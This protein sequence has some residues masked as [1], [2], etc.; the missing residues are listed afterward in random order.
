MSAGVRAWRVHPAPLRAGTVAVPGDKS[1]THRAI[2]LGLLAA[3]ETEV[4]GGNAGED[5]AASLA[6][7]AALGA[8]IDRSGDAWRITGVARRPA[9][10]LAPIDCG[11]SGT[12]LRLLA[13]V[14]AGAPI[15][16]ELTGDESLRRRPVDRV[17]RPLRAMGARA[18]AAGEDRFP[19]LVVE[20][21]SLRGVDFEQPTAS[22]QVASC[23]LL[24]ALSAEGRTTVRTRAGVRDHTLH[25]LRRFGVRVEVE[26]EA[27]GVMRASLTGP[28]TPEGTAFSVPGDPSAAAFFW[29][30]AAATPGLRL[31]VRGTNLNPT[32][33][34]LLAV[35]RR[36]GAGIEIVTRGEAGGEPCGDVAVTGAERLLATDIAGDEVP[37]LVDEVPAWAVA[38]AL[39]HGTSRL[40][41]AGELRVK[42]SDRLRVIAA[43]LGSLGIEVGETP[44]GLAITGGAPRGGVVR[45]HG[46]HRIA[47]AFAALGS[48][49]EGPVSVDDAAAV[50]TSFPGFESA[51]RSLGARLEVSAESAS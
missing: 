1:I 42:E 33:I 31:E 35:L 46:D 8:R 23:V 28:A 20:G 2:L 32:R 44:D 26:A 7:A 51:L 40:A 15:R 16:A 12:S 3:G 43:N 4:R 6:A 21:G 17:I 29:A 13:G 38:A 49:C 24:A 36:M 41:G 48:R 47:M 39:A 45:S 5:C 37:S 27:G 9:A 10:P 30:L 25:A 34:G 18:T 22:A 50:A 19:P 11:N 14:V